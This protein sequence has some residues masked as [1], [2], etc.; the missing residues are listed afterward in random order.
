MAV[1]QMTTQEIVKHTCEQDGADFSQV[2]VELSKSIQN[3]TTRIFRSGNSLIV[4]SIPQ[5]KVADIHL[6]TADPANKVVKALRDAYQAF[7]V[8]GFQKLVADVNNEGLF[9]L[10]RRAQIPFTST[11]NGSNYQL[12][13]EV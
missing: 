8:S 1:K 13:I 10:L 7:K 5:E 9:S 11:Q 4:Y 2:Y 6:F 3:G 12:L